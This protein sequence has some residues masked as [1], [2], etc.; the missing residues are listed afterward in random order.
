ML[1]NFRR[2]QT[3]RVSRNEPVLIM[4]GGVLADIGGFVCAL[5]HEI[6]YVMLAT[7]IVSGIMGPSPRTCCDGHGYR[8]FWCLSYSILCITDKSFK[9][10]EPGG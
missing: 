8:I 10:L 5:Y 9:T 3:A 7:S 2:F 1:E 4:G 6:P